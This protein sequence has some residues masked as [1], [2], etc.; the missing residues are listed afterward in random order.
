MALQ[1]SHNDAIVAV[2]PMTQRPAP[3][4]VIDRDPSGRVDD[5]S[6]AVVKSG[7]HVPKLHDVV[8]FGQEDIAKAR[9][10]QLLA[11]VKTS[12]L[13]IFVDVVGER[14]MLLVHNALVYTQLEREA[15]DQKET[16][17]VDPFS[18]E[19]IPMQERVLPSKRKSLKLKAIK[20]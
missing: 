10:I 2:R 16:E 8:C 5:A 14:V 13:G 7:N 20:Q 18:F 6:D 11:S 12:Q 3:T 4:I 19:I 17:I 9:I 1:L 15:P